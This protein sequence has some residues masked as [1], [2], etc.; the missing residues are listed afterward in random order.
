MEQISLGANQ[1]FNIQPTDLGGYQFSIEELNSMSLK[2]LDGVYCAKIFTTSNTTILN[3]KERLKEIVVFQNEHPVIFHNPSIM[4]GWNAITTESFERYQKFY[5]YDLQIL[6]YEKP[7]LNMGGMR[8]DKQPYH[9]N[10]YGY[11]MPEK[12]NSVVSDF[13]EKQQQLFHLVLDKIHE[14]ICFAGTKIEL[15]TSRSINKLEKIAENISGMNDVAVIDEMGLML[16][17]EDQR[18]GYMSEYWTSGLHIMDEMKKNNFFHPTH[19][20]PVITS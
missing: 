6:Q 4:R 10:S 12:L 16:K 15:I 19:L 5:E 14:K 3:Q 18:I 9:L 13:N 2:Q 7:F 1:K 17:K 20:S 11:P 8:D